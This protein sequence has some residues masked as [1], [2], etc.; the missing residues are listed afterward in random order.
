MCKEDLNKI[1]ETL[2]MRLLAEQ[3]MHPNG[4]VSASLQ[5]EINLYNEVVDCQ[6]KIDNALSKLDEY[7]EFCENDSGGAHDICNAAI[8]KMKKV[9]DIL[10]GNDER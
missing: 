2:Q 4:K 5:Q 3:A 8:N 6:E 1:W 9:R 10:R 7:I